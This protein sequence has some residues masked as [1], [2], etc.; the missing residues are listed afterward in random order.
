[1]RFLR[2]ATIWFRCDSY[3][4]HYVWH[5]AGANRTL[6]PET[7]SY[8]D[9]QFLASEDE[10]W[11]AGGG[12]DVL[13]VTSDSA[14]PKGLLNGYLDRGFGRAIGPHRFGCARRHLPV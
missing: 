9:H 3:V 8:V 14:G 1:M 10:V 13:A 2:D 6:V 4:R 5:F 11:L 12:L 7:A